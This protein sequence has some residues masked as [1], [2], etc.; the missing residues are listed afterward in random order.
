L[1][2]YTMVRLNIGLKVYNMTTKTFLAILFLLPLILF[3]QMT[4]EKV[5]INKVPTIIYRPSGYDA[6]KKYSVWLALHGSAEKGTGTL[7]GLDNLLNNGNFNALLTAADKNKFIVIEPQL[8][9]SL[10]DWMPGWTNKYLQPV[11]DYIINNPTTDLSH[12]VVTGLSLGGGGTWVAITGPFA[13][14]VSAAIPICGTPQYDQDY[15]IVAK[16][17]I[18]VWAFHAK[19]DKTVGYEATINTVAA[20]NKYDPLPVPKASIW[21]TGGHGIWGAAYSMTEVYS[22]ALSQQN[23]TG[24]VV[25]PTVPVDDVISTYKI[26]VYKSGKIEILKL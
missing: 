19:D 20:I 12:I 1:S 5:I 23:T 7:A 6:T 13:P 24:G 3:G 15:S 17:N 22:W 9:Q 8:V 2:P 14:Y 16:E 10:N 26:V 21:N 4:P 18:P 25:T 11:Y